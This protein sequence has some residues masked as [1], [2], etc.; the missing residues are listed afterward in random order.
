MKNSHEPFGAHADLGV[1][2]DLTVWI[3]LRSED[4]PL[5]FNPTIEIDRI[6]KQTHGQKSL[7]IKL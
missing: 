6:A 3:D 2:L 1:H 5:R 4:L 7:D